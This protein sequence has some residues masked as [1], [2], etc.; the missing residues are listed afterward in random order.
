[1]TYEGPDGWF[2]IRTQY[3]DQN[4]GVS[5]FRLFVGDQ[6]VDQ[7]IAEDNIPTRK[8]DGSSSTRRTTSGISLRKGDIIR[9]EGMP[10]GGETAALDYLEIVR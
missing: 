9:I 3:F 2:T 7:W 5:K 4:N 10:E 6:Q 8:P 1:M